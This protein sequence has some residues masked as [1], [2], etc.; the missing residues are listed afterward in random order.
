[1][2][3]KDLDL[4]KLI[5]LA[6]IMYG[7]YFIFFKK[8]SMIKDKNSDSETV[9]ECEECGVYVSM[10]ETILKDGKYYCSKECAGLK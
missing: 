6:A 10:K 1:M 3:K 8:P 7:I 4:I 2:D 5:L 9:V